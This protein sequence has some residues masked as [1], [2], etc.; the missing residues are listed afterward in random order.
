LWAKPEKVAGA[1]VTAMDGGGAV[2]YAPPF[3]RGVMLVI[4][5]L[6]QPFMNKV[7]L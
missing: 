2:V 1:I 3:W 5:L 6:P 7:N 4:R